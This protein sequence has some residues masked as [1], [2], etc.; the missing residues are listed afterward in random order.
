M[1]T[2][3]QEARRV[4]QSR[5]LQALQLSFSSG[6]RD[7]VN[8]ASFNGGS[9]NRRA[10]RRHRESD[11]QTSNKRLYRVEFWLIQSRAKSRDS[12]ENGLPAA[13]LQ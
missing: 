5:R 4:S 12:R 13:D 2:D 7:S 11:S 1:K 10:V 8:G 3:D 9:R 6:K